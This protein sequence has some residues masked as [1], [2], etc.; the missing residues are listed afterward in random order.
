MEH[1][2]ALALALAAGCSEVPHSQMDLSLEAR[3]TAFAGRVDGFEV[4]LWGGRYETPLVPVR[5]APG[6]EITLPVVIPLVPADDDASRIFTVEAELFEGAASLGTQRVIGRFVQNER[7]VLTLIFRP[8]CAAVVCGP[9][10]RCGEGGVCEPACFEEREGASV[11]VPC[12][13][14]PGGSCVVCEGDVCRPRP[15]TDGCFDGVRLSDAHGCASSAGQLFCWGSNAAGQLGIEGLRNASS[16]RQVTAPGAGSWD[17]FEVGG[18]AS[19]GVSGG[20][21]YCWGAAPSASGAAASIGTPSPVDFTPSGGW[22][23]LSLATGWLCGVHANGVS[24]AGSSDAYLRAEDTGVHPDWRFVDSSPLHACALDAAGRFRCWGRGGEGQRGDGG[25]VGG[26]SV[27]PTDSPAPDLEFSSLAVSVQHSCGVTTSG[28]LLCWGVNL[29]G[30]LGVE[31]EGFSGCRSRNCF[32]SPVQV[33]MQG[34]TAVAV[35]DDHSC[36]LRADGELYCWGSNRS[37]QL[38][39]PTPTPSVNVPTR[40]PV[41]DGGAWLEVAAAAR[42]TCALTRDHALYCWGNNAG[43]RLGIPPT[44]ADEILPTPRRVMR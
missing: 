21:L 10:Q 27:P 8:E 23:Q 7:R 17:L 25:L 4:R 22:S 43:A 37:G 12:A 32:V 30:Q 39:V 34:W 44:A 1:T 40:V 26:R 13:L 33:P 15:A 3:P 14:A 20:E 41:P 19:C 24:C 9:D 28:F 6:Q 29:D 11:S 35:G 31:G 16:P 5:P 18:D 42:Q 38:G 2:L 36:G